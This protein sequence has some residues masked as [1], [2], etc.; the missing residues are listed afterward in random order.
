MTHDISLISLHCGLRA[1]EIFN[2]VW[3]DIDFENKIILIKD[4]K[5]GRNRN[6]IMTED[7]KTMLKKRKRLSKSA[8]VFSSRIGEKITEVSRTFDRV[9]AALG[10]NDG[11]TDPRHKVV[12]HTLRHTYARKPL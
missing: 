8:L 11:V 3:N 2:L 5:S 1:G 12:F 7:V 6:V 10:F 4:T 9:I